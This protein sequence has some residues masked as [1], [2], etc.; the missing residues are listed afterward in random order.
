MRTDV[1]ITLPQAVHELLNFSQKVFWF[2][3]GQPNAAWPLLPKAGRAPFYRHSGPTLSDAPRSRRN[4]PPD[5][6]RFN[7]WRELAVGYCDSVPKNDFE[8][9][10][11]AQHYGFPTR[12]LDFTENALAALYFACASD[13]DV[14]GAVFVYHPVMFVDAATADLYTLDQNACLRVPPFDSRILAQRGLFVYFADPAVA[15]APGPI[16]SELGE[17]SSVSVDLIKFIV[18][19]AA[20][21]IIFRQLQDVGITRRTFFPDLEGL[22]RDFISDD[23]YLAAFNAKHIQP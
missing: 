15:L 16:D 3:R 8:A 17:L 7:H 18:P 6:G 12:L 21:L 9:L 14:D 10:A 4:P 20:K 22:S 5:L 23:E 13:F 11:F 2:Y 1:L 19:A